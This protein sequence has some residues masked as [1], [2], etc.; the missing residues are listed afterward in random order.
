MIIDEHNLRNDDI[1]IENFEAEPYNIVHTTDKTIREE[2]VSEHF[3]EN[4]PEML[5][6]VSRV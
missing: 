6:E 1:S 2:I 4:V 5:N 3:K